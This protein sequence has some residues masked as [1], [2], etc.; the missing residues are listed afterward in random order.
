MIWSGEKIRVS[1]LLKILFTEWVS[2][3]LALSLAAHRRAQR[4]EC[5]ERMVCMRELT[6]V[7]RIDE[8]S[9][10]GSRVVGRTRSADGTYTVIL[11]RDQIERELKVE[12]FVVLAHEIGHVIGYEFNLPKHV[13]VQK[14]NSGFISVINQENEAWDVAEAM[15]KWRKFAINHYENHVGYSEQFEI[16]E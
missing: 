11:D 12:P 10:S 1:L 3:P 7:V 6:I 14:E 13:E 4:R 5:Y 2:D 9:Q 15:F 16:S 8:N